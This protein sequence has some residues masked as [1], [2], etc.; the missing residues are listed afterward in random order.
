MATCL[1]SYVLQH[2]YIIVMCL[3]HTYDFIGKVFIFIYW[4][5]NILIMVRVSSCIQVVLG[6]IAVYFFLVMFNLF[7]FIL[8]CL[9]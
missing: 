8:F 3:K 6:K 9:K 5:I 7:Y 4:S 1:L 2:Q